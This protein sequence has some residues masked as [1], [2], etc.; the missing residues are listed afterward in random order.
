MREYRQRI[1]EVSSGREEKR[2]SP[3]LEEAWERRQRQARAE[4]EAA[5]RQADESWQNLQVWSGCDGWS[6]GVDHVSWE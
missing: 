2:L 1:A 5:M 6:D 4:R 3:E